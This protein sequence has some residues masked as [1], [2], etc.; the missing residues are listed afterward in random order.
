VRSWRRHWYRRRAGDDVEGRG[1][2]VC[3]NSLFYLIG[4]AEQMGR[5]LRPVIRDS[6]WRSLEEA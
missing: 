3:S 4:C 5:D 2:G 6:Y 1:H